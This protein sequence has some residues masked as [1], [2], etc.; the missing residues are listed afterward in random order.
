MK[1][2]HSENEN[3]QEED[4]LVVVKFRYEDGQEYGY[5]VCE[6]SRLTS[7]QLELCM[8]LQID[9]GICGKTYKVLNEEHKVLSEACSFSDEHDDSFLFRRVDDLRH[10]TI[11]IS[12]IIDC[13]TWI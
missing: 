5:L 10:T 7:E 3:D 13:P 12:C 11:P 1:K 8:K 6:R 4:S 9:D 2:R